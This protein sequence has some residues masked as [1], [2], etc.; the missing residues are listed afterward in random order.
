MGISGILLITILSYLTN[1]VFAHNLVHNSI[2]IAIGLVA[3]FLLFKKRLFRKKISLILSISLVLYVR[4]T[5]DWL[6]PIN[7]VPYSG[8]VWR[9]ESLANR[10]RFAKLK[11]SKLVVTIDNP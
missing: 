10:L 4:L 8:K 5:I 7:E 11:P 1:F 6:Q 9:G 3:F 2:F